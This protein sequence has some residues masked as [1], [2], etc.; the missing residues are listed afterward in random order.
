MEKLSYRDQ[1]LITVVLAILIGVAGY[2][3]LLKPTYER[4]VSTREELE[5][6]QAEWDE[7]ESKIL[8]I[9]TIKE[10]IQTKYNECV[11]LGNLFVDV[12]RS[13]TLEDFI[14]GFIDKNGIY[15]KSKASFTDP[16][17]TTLSPYSL[18][19]Q[20]LD[21]SIGNS[22]NLEKLSENSEEDT[23]NQSAAI[24]PQMLPFGTTS[25]D[26]TAT[27]ASLMQFLEDIKNSGKTIEV[28]SLSIDSE[29]YNT[30]PDA[31]LTG[32]LSIDVYYADMITDMDIA[33]EIEAVK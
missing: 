32:N 6:V 1:I 27:R 21:Y 9:D 13:D 33:A 31:Y 15:I 24:E 19:A 28:K 22:A 11:Q 12:K 29:K 8:Q 18:T 25:I 23:N 5:T 14:K 17:I 2:M 20:I 16:S 10:R 7:L 4:I 30:D 3:F 26:F